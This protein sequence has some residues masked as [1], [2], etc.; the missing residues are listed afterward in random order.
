VAWEI[1]RRGGHSPLGDR[2]REEFTQRREAA[3]SIRKTPDEIRRQA[4]DE[5]RAI[6]AGMEHGAPA[7]AARAATPMISTRTS[8]LER[9]IGS[10]R[11]ELGRDDFGL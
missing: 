3:A 8:D 5:W 2:A 4:I 11:R 6:R 10:L 7:A 9:Q 1:E